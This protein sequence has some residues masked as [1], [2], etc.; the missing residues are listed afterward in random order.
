TTTPFIICRVSNPLDGGCF[1]GSGKW[2]QIQAQRVVKI[3]TGLSIFWRK[4][5]S[6][7]TE[8]PPRLSVAPTP[9]ITSIAIIFLAA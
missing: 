9:G 6:G 1:P 3:P 5:C 4:K 2:F 7:T 8:Y